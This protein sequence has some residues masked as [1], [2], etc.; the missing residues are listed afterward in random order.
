MNYT[1]LVKSQKY[2]ESSQIDVNI[3]CYETKNEL[4]NNFIEK[5]YLFYKQYLSNSFNILLFSCLV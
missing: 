2:K 3:L 1:S 5:Q 4:S